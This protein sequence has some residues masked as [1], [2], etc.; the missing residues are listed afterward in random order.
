MS[1]HNNL[2]QDA[3]A[4]GKGEKRKKVVGHNCCRT[5]LPRSASGHRTPPRGYHNEDKIMHG[6]DRLEVR[7][8]SNVI[9]L[10]PCMD[11]PM[12][13]VG[14]QANHQSTRTQARRQSRGDPNSSVASH[15][16]EQGH[17]SNFAATKIVGRAGT[18][19]ARE[20]VEAWE[21]GPLSVN[22]SVDLSPAYQLL[23]R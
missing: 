4:E 19:I 11:C 17:T 8:T 23:R 22:R 7:D 5:Q 10:I 14:Q 20:T 6:K 1:T 13:Y 16:N 3:C 9:Y 2:L 18:K 15:C 21:T 12:D